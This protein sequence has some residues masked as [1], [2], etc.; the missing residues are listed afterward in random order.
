[1]QL[2]EQ[3]IIS[4]SDPRFAAIDAASFAAKNLYNLALY[5]VRQSF[6]HEGIYL[7]R[8]GG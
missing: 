8:C 4:K 1:M 3:T 7:F 6:L 5:E 2:V